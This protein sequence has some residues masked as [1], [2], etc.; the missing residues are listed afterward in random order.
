VE[1][2]RRAIFADPVHQVLDFGHDAFTRSLTEIIDDRVFQRLRRVSQ[3]GL[4]SYV[5]PGAT[6]TR[7]LHSLGAAHLA[8]LVVRHLAESTDGLVPD[9]AIMGHERTVMVA[10]L[11]H[12]IGHGPFSHAFERVRLANAEQL[13]PT[14][15]EWGCA[16]IK[17]L[18]ADKIRGAGVDPSHL[19]AIIGKSKTTLPVPMFVKQIVSSQLDVDRL[20]YLPR[21]AHFAGVSMGQVDVA[22]LI[23]SMAIVKVGRADCLGL[24]KKGI[25]PYEAFALA[26]HHMNRSVYFHPTVRVLEFMMEEFLRRVL[27]EAPKDSSLPPYLRAVAMLTKKAGERFV[28]DNLHHYVAMTEDAVWALVEDFASRHKGR[29]PELAKR[30][31]ARRVMWFSLVRRG[32]RQQLASALKEADRSTYEII[33]AD[34]TVYKGNSD[35]VL[36]MRGDRSEPISGESLAIALHMDRPEGDAILVALDDD[37]ALLRER[38][39]GTLLVEK[40][41]RADKENADGKKPLARTRARTRQASDASRASIT[42]KFAPRKTLPQASRTGRKPKPRRSRAR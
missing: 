33:S 31:L 35:A 29:A 23:R 6:H 32:M 11:L 15:E 41:A 8:R 13:A 25:R 19:T 1:K 9:S 34:S 39:A 40:E 5:F 3:L 30:L 38:A 28:R 26:R 27:N 37:H 12:D 36:V 14:H 24:S 17:E 10:A 21:D 16:I 22:Y 18:L 2:Y 7:F 42:L 20:D 4:A